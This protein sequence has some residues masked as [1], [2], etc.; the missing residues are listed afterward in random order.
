MLHILV[1][2]VLLSRESSAVFSLGRLEEYP[3]SLGAINQWFGVY[4]VHT[5]IVITQEK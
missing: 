1:L 2:E 3:N 5:Y 4:V